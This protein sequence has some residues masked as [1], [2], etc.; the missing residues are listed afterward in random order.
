MALTD[1]CDVFASINESAFRRVISH[2]TRQRPSLFNYGSAGVQQ[3]A[4]L[5]CRPIDVHPVAAARGDMLITAL[6]SLPVVFTDDPPL[7]M[8]WCVQLSKAGLDVHPGNAL[9]LPP[10]LDPLREQRLA[11]QVAVCAGVGCPEETLR[12]LLPRPQLSVGHT[13]VIDRVDTDKEV[14]KRPRPDKPPRPPVTVP[15]RK[16]ECFCLEADLVA[17]A[18]FVGPAGDQHFRGILSGL[19]IVDLAPQGLE[20]AIECY[21]K[22]V[23]IFG[24]LPKLSVPVIRFTTDLLGLVALAIEPTPSSADVPNNPALED[25]SIKLFIDLTAQSITGGGGGGSGGGAAPPSFPGSP[26]TRTRTGPFDV[27][28]AGSERATQELFDAIRDG[29]KLDVA[30]SVDFG[31]FTAGYDVEAHLEGGTVDLRPNG[32]IAL[33]E[34]DVE[35]DVL[36]FFAGIDIPEV[37]VGGFCIIPNPFGGCLVRAPQICAFSA[38]P[39]LGINLDLS[40]LLVSEVSAVVEPIVKYSVNPGRT[41]GMNDWDAHDAG[42]PNHWQLYIDPV[43]IDLDIFDFADIVGNLLEN[44]LNAAIDNLLGPLPDWAK[45]LIRA[46]LGPIIDLVRD[47]LDIGDDLQE[48]LSQLLGTSLGLINVI[49]TFIADLLATSPIIEF[50]DPL[51]L[52][53]AE[54]GKMAVLLPVEFLGVEVDDTELQLQVDVGD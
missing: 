40:G 16:L 12:E 25:D 48:W 9:A 49:L 19:E 28:A 20:D 36:H 54:P 6:P 3:R 46:L 39:D 18:D 23:A 1:H 24:L 4:E 45:D 32:T 44:A 51:P 38:N 50:P 35:W 33:N 34:L 5:L 10:E 13:R 53:E 7:Q 11:G 41:A 30:D 43:S 14:D 29:A 52:L 15:T 47:I 8:D 21:S 22:L 42:V 31:P 37:C 17:G 2:F 27:L 26:R